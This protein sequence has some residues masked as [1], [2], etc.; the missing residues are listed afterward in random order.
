MA[1]QDTPLPIGFDKTISPGQ[2]HWSLHDSNLLGVEAATATPAAQVGTGLGYQAR[3]DGRRWAR[4]L[5]SVADRR[6]S[7]PMRRG[8]ASPRS[9]TICR[10]A[11]RRRLARLGR[12]MDAFRPRFWSR[13]RRPIAPPTALR[14]AAQARSVGWLIPRLSGAGQSGAI[15]LRRESTADQRRRR[16]VPTIMPRFASQSAAK[17]VTSHRAVEPVG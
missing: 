9:A 15:E 16:P 13:A 5:V 11:G 17:Q 3:G 10:R 7:S 14:R 6:R 4:K 1:Y 8:S 12:C 2:F